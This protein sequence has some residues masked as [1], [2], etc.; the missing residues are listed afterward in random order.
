MIRCTS[1]RVDL[2]AL[3]T[4]YNAIRAH[5]DNEAAINRTAGAGAP[6]APGIIAVVKANAYAS[7]VNCQR[8]HATAADC[9]CIATVPAKR[10]HKKRRRL[11]VKMAVGPSGYFLRI[12][13]TARI[14]AV[15]T[16]A[17]ARMPITTHEPKSKRL[18][19]SR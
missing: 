8:C 7:P 15:M 12:A 3:V 14:T 13:R 17:T 4:N 9:T 2:G 5:L 18:P 10:E 6:R 11:R 1:A 16:T 19:S